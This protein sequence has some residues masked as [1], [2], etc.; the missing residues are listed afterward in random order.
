MTSRLPHCVWVPNT[1]LSTSFS[2]PYNIYLTSTARQTPTYRQNTLVSSTQTRETLASYTSFEL[3]QVQ[4]GPSAHRTL[5]ATGAHLDY[6][7]VG[8][9]PNNTGGFSS[10]VQAAMPLS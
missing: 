7:N 10:A 5:D 4:R 9:M 2:K 1:D 6:G 3:S 8:N